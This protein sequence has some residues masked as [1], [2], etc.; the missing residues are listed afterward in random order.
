MWVVKALAYRASTLW[1]GCHSE[2]VHSQAM[3]RMCGHG[4]SPQVVFAWWT[5]ALPVHGMVQSV[6]CP[7]A[8]A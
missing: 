1:Y 3:Q 7:W 2:L 4:R 5:A 8:C 6:E